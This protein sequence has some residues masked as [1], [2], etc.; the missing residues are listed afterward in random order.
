MFHCCLVSFLYDQEL[1]YTIDNSDGSA[2]FLSGVV[3]IEGQVRD[4]QMT[5]GITQSISDSRSFA[6]G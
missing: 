6:S 3:T 2:L 1:T 4:N 5:T